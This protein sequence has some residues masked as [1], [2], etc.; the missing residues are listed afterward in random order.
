METFEYERRLG[1]QV[2]NCQVCGREHNCC[3]HHIQAGSGRFHSRVIWV[4]DVCH[5][6]IHNPLSF[7]LPASWAYDNGYLVKNN[8]LYIKRVKK[9][10]CTHSVTIFNKAI[11]DFTCQ[12]CG[13]RVGEL[14][15]GKH[16]EQKV[17]KASMKMGYEKRDE[18][19]VK[20][21]E[22]KRHYQEL[23][24][25]IKREVDPEAKKLFTKRK[26]ELQKEMQNFQNTLDNE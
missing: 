12:F 14:R 19:I 24:L 5:S 2:R 4:D 21:E 10:K 16:K 23:S 9:Q 17:Q 8:F 20:A 15:M 13:A 1:Y 18:R 22:R 3:Q 6:K 7:G 26:N 25:K 11:G